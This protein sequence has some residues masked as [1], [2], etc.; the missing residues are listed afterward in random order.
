MDRTHALLTERG[1]TSKEGKQTRHYQAVS[2]VCARITEELP[3]DIKILRKHHPKLLA[4]ETA[5]RLLI[6]ITT[7][8]V[9][10]GLNLDGSLGVLVICIGII[11]YWYIGD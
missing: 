2:E 7:L 6:I 9:A 11:S 8:A 5:K 10:Y 3:K 1:F 4:S